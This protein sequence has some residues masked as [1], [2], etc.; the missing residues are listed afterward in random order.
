MMRKKSFIALLLL[1]LCISYIQPAQKATAQVAAQGQPNTDCQVCDFPIDQTKIP[2]NFGTF[3]EP[4]GGSTAR[5]ISEDNWICGYSYPPVW[6]DPDNG[7]R[8]EGDPEKPLPN[9]SVA[10]VVTGGTTTRVDIPEM[11]YLVAGA[12]QKSGESQ[13]HLFGGANKAGKPAFTFFKSKKKGWI[14]VQIDDRP[15][16]INAMSSDGKFFVGEVIDKGLLQP[17]VYSADKATFTVMASPFGN[18]G[19]FT[20]VNDLGDF[21]GWGMNTAGEKHAYVILTPKAKFIDL[22]VETSNWTKISRLTNCREGAVDSERA[23]Y[24]TQINGL[25]LL[26]TP[27]GTQFGHAFGLNGTV[28]V[29]EIGLIEG[30]GLGSRPAYWWLGKPYRLITLPSGPNGTAYWV[31][32]EGNIVGR[33]DNFAGHARAVLWPA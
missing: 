6:I 2:V 22:G 17:F 11:A 27:A 18:L 14:V 19:A 8:R 21:G 1:M 31:N 16:R 33:S 12:I 5:F 30:N 3:Y 28:L 13:L 29:G 9:I 15:G 7:Q 24:W 32:E 10:F 4:E 25:R 23:F 20:T 26:C